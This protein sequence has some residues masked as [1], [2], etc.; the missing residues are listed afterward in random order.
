MT[1]LCPL[2]NFW[3]F[4]GCRVAHALLPKP[5]FL[6]SEG[7]HTCKQ[8][9]PWL[10]DAAISFWALCSGLRSTVI[11]PLHPALQAVGIPLSTWWDDLLQ[12]CRAGVSFATSRGGL[13]ITQ[14]CSFCEVSWRSLMSY[15]QLAAMWPRLCSRSSAQNW[16]WD[17]LNVICW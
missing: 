7:A 2:G 15:V 17:C 12:R 1:L 11:A 4:K 8:T 3:L 14:G 5:P 9:F 13:D 6:L 10:N 16:D